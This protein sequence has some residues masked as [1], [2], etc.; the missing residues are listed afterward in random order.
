MISYAAIFCM[1]NHIRMLH[2][3]IG[4]YKKILPLLIQNL[5]GV[6]LNINPIQ[7]IMCSSFVDVR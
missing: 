5:N 1:I 4:S 2:R 6:F 3:L 7:L